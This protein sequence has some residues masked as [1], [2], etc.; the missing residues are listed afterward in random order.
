MDR[1]HPL[2]T[3]KPFH[4][5]QLVAPSKRNPF[6]LVSKKKKK[7]KQV[8]SASNWPQSANSYL[9]LNRLAQRVDILINEYELGCYKGSKSHKPCLMKP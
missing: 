8:F 2:H 6:Y 4:P 3:T 5:S 1:N 7:K 9:P